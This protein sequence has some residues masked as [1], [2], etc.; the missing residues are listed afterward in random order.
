MVLFGENYMLTA[1]K[2]R[3]HQLKVQEEKREKL[4]ILNNEISNLSNKYKQERLSRIRNILS[5]AEFVGFLKSAVEEGFERIIFR[6]NSTCLQSSVCNT[7]K[8]YCLF[9]SPNKKTE[10]GELFY[11]VMTKAGYS[12]SFGET[13]EDNFSYVVTADGY[14]TEACPGVHTVYS[15]TVS[16]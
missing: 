15:V 9:F 3:E 13:E 5:D 10:E 7:W 16:W 8:S 14:E 6:D 4:E 1:D 2:L 11:E 12:V